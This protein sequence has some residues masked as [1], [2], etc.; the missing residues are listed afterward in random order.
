MEKARK[1]HSSSSSSSSDHELDEKIYKTEKYLLKKVLE[2]LE[3]DKSIKKKVEKIEDK[4]DK[5]IDDECI[6]IKTFPVTLTKSGTYCI[7][8][9]KT[10]T[11]PGA[12]ITVLADNVTIK[13]QAT[14][15][16]TDITSIGVLVDGPNSPNGKINNFTLIG[17]VYR[18]GNA[19]TPPDQT[20]NGVR[21]LTVNNVN[22]VGVTTIG[23]ARG[24]NL[25]L[26]NGGTVQHCLIQDTMGSV[27]GFIG[28]NAYS[29]RTEGSN[30]IVIDGCT[31]TGAS[32]ALNGN[33]TFGVALSAGTGPSGITTPVSDGIVVKNCSFNKLN[34]P[35][36]IFGNN[37]LIKDCNSS[38]DPILGF[39]TAEI[40]FADGNPADQ[41]PATDIQFIDCNFGTITDPGFQ[42]DGL[43][44][45]LGSNCLVQ[46]CTLNGNTDP[47]G[48]DTAIHIG[49]KNAFGTPDSIFSSVRIVDTIING[50]NQEAILIDSGANVTIDNVTISDVTINGIHLLEARNVTIKNSDIQA[51]PG[52]TG[53]GILVEA[54]ARN[55]TIKGNSIRDFQAGDGIHV[56]SKVTI[57]RDNEIYSN[58]AGIVI[59]LPAD[60]PVPQNNILFNNP[61]VI[62]LAKTNKLPKLQERKKLWSP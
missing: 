18:Y 54:P 33:V 50:P 37:I 31:V 43:L 26:C 55:V 56:Q 30:G 42:P 1:N 57:V 15:T 40:G 24:I 41:F 61:T 8:K 62:T 35:Y 25:T 9:D 4:I 19:A 52:A 16:T 48:V 46:G 2:D 58:N 22:V 17:G 45:V 20:V 21:L 39:A 12:A 3:V 23:Y 60:N 29:I 13:S 38:L 6:E 28:T 27:T 7:K 14:I 49:T 47:V 10:V 59:D 5:L 44:F 53:D 34:L 32:F 51:A 36:G 11:T